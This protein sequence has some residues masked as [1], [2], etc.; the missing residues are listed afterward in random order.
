MIPGWPYSVI[1]ELEP[2]RTSWTAPL[3]APAA[4]ASTILARSRS[5]YSLRADRARAASTASSPGGQDNYVRARHSHLI[6]V[7]HPRTGST[8]RHAGD[9][10]TRQA[11]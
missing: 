10:E 3:V 6:F 8:A 7:P 1:A 11:R 4:A 5:R 2:G 9:R